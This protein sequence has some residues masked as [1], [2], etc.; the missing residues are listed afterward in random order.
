MS[1]LSSTISSPTTA[2]STDVRNPG[3]KKSEDVETDYEG[4]ESTEMRI[5][6]GSESGPEAWPFIVALH[7]DGRFI[8]GATIVGAQW[9]ITA[10]HCL[11]EFDTKQSLFQVFILSEILRHL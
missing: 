2:T 9:I 5:V 6:G 1:L 10:G 3:A 4:D 7:R 8:C 11:D